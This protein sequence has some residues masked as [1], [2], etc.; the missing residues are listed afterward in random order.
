MTFIAATS[1]GGRLARGVF[2]VIGQEL[3]ELHR[4][5]DRARLCAMASLSVVIAVVAALAL[6]FGDPWWA[7]IS[8]FISIQSSRAGS[9]RRGSLRVLGTV[10]GAI[11]GALTAPWLAY[12]H[13]A[14][15]LALFSFTFIGVLG[16]TVSRYGYA[17]LFVGVTALMVVLASLDDPTVSLNV[18]FDRGAEIITGVLAAMFVAFLFASDEPVEIAAAPGW[19]DLGGAQWPAVLHATRSGIVV[20]ALPFIWN[21]LEVPD[22][23]QIVITVA[24]VVAVPVSS[25]ALD[26]GRQIASRGLHRLVGCLLGGCA[27]LLALWLSVTEF[28]PWLALLSAGVWVGAHVQASERGIGYVGTQ[29]TVVFMMTLIQGNGPPT[30]ILPG[31]DRFTAITCGLISLLVMSLLLQPGLLLPGRERAAADT[32]RDTP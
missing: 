18:A 13:V 17:W 24:A 9:I 5:G 3:A 27:G 2:A 26:Q 6:H 4:P 7:A 23:A 25:T 16:M 14:C 30:S 22:L 12:H 8:G 10:A 28:L 1:E 15:C 31:I 21:W 20:A 29:G 11:V 19:S 32:P